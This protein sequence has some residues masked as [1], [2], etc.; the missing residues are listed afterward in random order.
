MEQA[1]A[2]VKL[3]GEYHCRRVRDFGTRDGA[4]A[5]APSMHYGHARC[6]GPSHARVVVPRFLSLFGDLTGYN[7]RLTTTTAYRVC[8]VTDDRQ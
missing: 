7:R 6:R 5:S 4:F 8:A 3:E 2:V 1:E